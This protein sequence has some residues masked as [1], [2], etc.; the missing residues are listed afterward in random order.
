MSQTQINRVILFAALLF[1]SLMAWLLYYN[2]YGF[3]AEND[4]DEAYIKDLFFQG[5]QAGLPAEE[6]VGRLT[7]RFPAIKCDKVEQGETSL[8]PDFIGYTCI[9][10]TVVNHIG[11]GF[12]TLRWI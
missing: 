10:P 2:S 9:G 6:A 4:R 7:E 12:E 1:A 11:Y 5:R 8:M 3:T